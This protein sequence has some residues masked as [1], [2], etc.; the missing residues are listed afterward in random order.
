MAGKAA[1]GYEPQSVFPSPRYY[2]ARCYARPLS[3]AYY[4]FR[5]FGTV[6]VRL[7]AF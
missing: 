4:A 1:D 7:R 2:K 6:A 3:A 5:N